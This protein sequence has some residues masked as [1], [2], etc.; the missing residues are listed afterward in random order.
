MTFGTMSDKY[1]SVA[2]GAAELDCK[3]CDGS[4]LDN[5]DEAPRNNS[6]RVHTKGRA[7]RRPHAH[8]AITNLRRLALPPAAGD[9]GTAQAEQRQP[10]GLSERLYAVG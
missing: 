6:V 3:G 2:A 5:D 10:R 8:H 4:E 7:K 9:A 1:K